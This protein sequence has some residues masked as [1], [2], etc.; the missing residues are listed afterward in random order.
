MQISERR[1]LATQG[2]LNANGTISP[3]LDLE[4]FSVLGLMIHDTP[5]IGT[6]TFQAG[7]GNP[8]NLTWHT[9]VDNAGD[10]E[11]LTLN[12]S[13]A[14]GGDSLK[15]LEPYRY[16][17]MVSSVQQTNGLQFSITMKS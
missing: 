8:A 5:A 16:V 13:V 6:L 12:A 7:S 10:A 3:Q 14:F 17:R 1:Y 2:T 11:S 4:G 15:F 9:I